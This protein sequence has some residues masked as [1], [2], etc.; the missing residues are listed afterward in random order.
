MKITVTLENAPDEIRKNL[1]LQC[2]ENKDM[3][4]ETLVQKIDDWLHRRAAIDAGPIPKKDKFAELFQ[5]A[6][7]QP[8]YRS[9]PQ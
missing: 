5:W 7:F 6:L 1:E 9:S 3:T 4:C 8:G 2:A